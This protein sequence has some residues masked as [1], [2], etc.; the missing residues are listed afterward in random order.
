MSKWVK[1]K[2]Y[3]LIFNKLNRRVDRLDNTKSFKENYIYNAK[4]V[5]QIIEKSKKEN[6]VKTETMQKQEKE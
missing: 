1:W 4:K 5:L 3:L 6:Q 2:G